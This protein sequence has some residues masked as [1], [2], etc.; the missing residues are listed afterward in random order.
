[1][2]I[3]GKRLLVLSP[4]GDVRQSI[5]LPGNADSMACH[6]DEVFLFGGSH[7]IYVLPAAPH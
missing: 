4:D 6:G 1:M 5:H 3:E 7:A 2:E